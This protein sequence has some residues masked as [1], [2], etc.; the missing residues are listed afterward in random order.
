[1]FGVNLFFNA[2]LIGAIPGRLPSVALLFSGVLAFL[3]LFFAWRLE[4]MYGG[5]SKECDIKPVQVVVI[6]MILSGLAMLMLD[7]TI[8]LLGG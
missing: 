5:Q 3:P 4:T 1:M 2:T 7:F 6:I 8:G